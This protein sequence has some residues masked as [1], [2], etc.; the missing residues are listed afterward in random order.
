MPEII[1]TDD[2]KLELEYRT[3]EHHGI[4]IALDQFMD[5]R[6]EYNADH[7]NRLIETYIK[8]HVERQ[9]CL[10]AVLAK[11]GINKC[12]KDY[13]VEGNNLILRW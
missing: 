6:H 12:P 8:K 13:M 5:G 4:Q 9:K 11:R 1:L 10:C 3:F 2:E 7:Y